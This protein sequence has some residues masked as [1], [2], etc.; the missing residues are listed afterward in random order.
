[1]PAARA[2]AVQHARVG[3]VLVVHGVAVLVQR[4]VQA[5]VLARVGSGVQ[6]SSCASAGAGPQGRLA[7]SK[8]TPLCPAEPH[9]DV[10]EV[11]A[12]PV[13]VGPELQRDDLA[14]ERGGWQCG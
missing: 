13:G 2:S 1:M 4:R 14:P 10:P 3:V 8:A 11:C 7:A 6:L 5:L 12:D 9:L